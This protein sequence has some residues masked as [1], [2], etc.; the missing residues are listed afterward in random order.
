MKLD[1]CRATVEN[2]EKANWNA[3]ESK[4][5]CEG[6]YIYIYINISMAIYTYKDSLSSGVG[7]TLLCGWINSL[8]LIIHYDTYAEFETQSEEMWRC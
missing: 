5:D 8:L 1:N 2:A 6:W 4:F 3:T 7:V